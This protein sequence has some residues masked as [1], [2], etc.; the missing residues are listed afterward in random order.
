MKYIKGKKVR[1]YLDHWEN[2]RFSNTE[3]QLR[4]ERHITL[5][6]HFPSHVIL[7]PHKKLWALSAL[8]IDGFPLLY[9]QFTGDD[10]GESQDAL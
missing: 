10:S 8:R 6:V 5:G 2:A 7:F 1:L 3:K 4:Q 9:A